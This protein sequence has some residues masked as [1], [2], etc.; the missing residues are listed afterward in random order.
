M[1]KII[2]CAA[3]MFCLA[4]ASASAW[5]ASYLLTYPKPIE[6]GNWLLDLGIG[7]GLPG[8]GSLLIPPI[9]LTVEYALPIADLPFSVGGL[10]GLSGSHWKSW[11]G[12]YDH[13]YT[14][15]YLSFGGRIAYHFNW[16]VDKLDTYVTTTLG[17]TIGFRSWEWP[18]H[19]NNDIWG[20]FLFGTHIGARYYFIP[21]VGA[22]IELGGWS[23]HYA[24]LG[25]AFRF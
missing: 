23:P 12:S 2:G 19:K 25:V 6:K 3:I 13:E 24:A 10:V 8:E 21:N 15:I 16:G 22:F 7:F 5:D 17:W 18:G 9:M 1:K 11:Q 14:A 4:G 20:A